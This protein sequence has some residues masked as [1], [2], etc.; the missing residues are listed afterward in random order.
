MKRTVKLVMRKETVRDLSCF[1]IVAAIG[2]G[3]LMQL[4]GDSTAAG[5]CAAMQL[6]AVSA[7]C[8]K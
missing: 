1:E 3:N 8:A 6:L 5:T 4:D 7:V 2:G